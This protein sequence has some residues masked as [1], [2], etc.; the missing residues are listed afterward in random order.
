M[1][2]WQRNCSDGELSNG[3]LQFSALLFCN[4]GDDAD[5]DGFLLNFFWVIIDV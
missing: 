5:W 4:F 1:I 3:P 2:A